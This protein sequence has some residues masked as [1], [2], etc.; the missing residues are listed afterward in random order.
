MGKMQ[1]LQVRDPHPQEQLTQFPS[2]PGN[3]FVTHAAA[4]ER[5]EAEIID[6][7]RRQPGLMAQMAVGSA[8][9]HILHHVITGYFSGG[10]S[11]EPSSP[12]IT[13]QEPQGTQLPQLQQNGPCFYEVKQFSECAQSQGDLQFCDGFSEVLK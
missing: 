1:T 8:V 3:E 6:K 11:T 12:D 5:V 13:Y 7:T 2:H 4:S 10:S 9:G